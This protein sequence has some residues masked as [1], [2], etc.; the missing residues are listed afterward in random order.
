[1]RIAIPAAAI[2]EKADWHSR[3][4]SEMEV[5]CLLLDKTVQETGDALL[6][7]SGTIALRLAVQER[8]EHA[9]ALDDGERKLIDLVSPDGQLK[10][11]CLIPTGEEL[12]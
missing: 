10:L 11:L 5:G 7:P 1:M 2:E 12:G 6:I 4:P 9:L 8:Y 3:V